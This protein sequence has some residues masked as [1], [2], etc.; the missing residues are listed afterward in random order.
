MVIRSFLPLTKSDGSMCLSQE[1]CDQMGGRFFQHLAIYN[2][3][4][5]QITFKICK[6]RLKYDNQLINSSKLSKTSNKFFKSGPSVQE[7][8]YI[9]VLPH[10]ACKLTVKWTF[11]SFEQ[12]NVF[13]CSSLLHAICR[14]TYLRQLMFNVFYAPQNRI[15]LSHK[16]GPSPA[17]YSYLFSLF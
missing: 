1:Q 8:G 2:N 16:E 12:K 4:T 15:H 6:I 17:S 13:Y 14:Q 5:C 7:Y 3:K 11:Y 9:K 10:L